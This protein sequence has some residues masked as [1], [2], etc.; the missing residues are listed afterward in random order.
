M[1]RFQS[2]PQIALRDALP[3]VGGLCRKM[4]VH[5]VFTETR[6][7][8]LFQARPKPGD[9]APATEIAAR[10]LEGSEVL[11]EIIIGDSE[12]FRH[13]HIHAPAVAG[14]KEVRPG[15]QVVLVGERRIRQHPR[16]LAAAALRRIHDERTI[17]E[18][19]TRQTAGQNENFLP[20]KNVAAAGPRGGP[21]SGRRTIVGTRESASVG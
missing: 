13:R 21:R 20:V 7:R 4:H 5:F 17:L 16:V 11:F 6:E 9:V 18:R 2:P 10:L 1:N 8:M 19:D 14:P 12:R 3:V 15:A